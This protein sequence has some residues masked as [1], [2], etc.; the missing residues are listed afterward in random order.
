METHLMICPD[1][2]Q[3]LAS[4]TALAAVGMADQ[5]VAQTPK[6]IAANGPRQRLRFDEGWRFAL[7]H[8][9]DAAKDFN[10]GKGQD[11]FAKQGAGGGDAAG[12]GFDD[13][14]WREVSLPHDWAVELPFV[15]S[16]EAKSLK[17]DEHGMVW[18]PA[19]NH[20]YKPL[21]RAY[22]ATSIGWYR[23]A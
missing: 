18:D 5:A 23:K 13:S 11:T 12:L 17:P 4:A 8:L 3:L 22:P 2:R 21:G 15:D 19:A 7:G 6:A 20:G 14:G 9:E 16:P 10:F 1:R